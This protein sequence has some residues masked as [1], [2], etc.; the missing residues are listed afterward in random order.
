MAETTKK[1]KEAEVEKEAVAPVITYSNQE[2]AISGVF[3]CPPE[4]VM[5][6]FRENGKTRATLD[7]AQKLVKA[8]LTKEVK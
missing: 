3:S 2:F 5:A 6:A 8:F 1:A 4:C 7:E